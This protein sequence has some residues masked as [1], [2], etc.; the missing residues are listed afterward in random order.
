MIMGY[1]ALIPY[2]KLKNYR[3]ES[4]PMAYIAKENFLGAFNL[5]INT[6]P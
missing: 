2:K 1:R 4:F 6:Y 3:R 5:L